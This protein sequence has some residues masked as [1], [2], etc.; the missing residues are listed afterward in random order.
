[1]QC[2]DIISINWSNHEH[3]AMQIILVF[4]TL[5]ILVILLVIHLRLLNPENSLHSSW[6]KEYLLMALNCLPSLSSTPVL[7][8]HYLST[9]IWD[10]KSMQKCTGASYA[11]VKFFSLTKTQHS[12]IT[13]R[14]HHIQFSHCKHVEV[15]MIIRASKRMLVCCVFKDPHPPL[16][17]E[18]IF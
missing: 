8:I 6:K 11:V 13:P 9:E 1:M 10:R 12:N 7:I 16:Y 4:S 2:H 18:Y 15:K 17:C 3:T 5:F 14:L